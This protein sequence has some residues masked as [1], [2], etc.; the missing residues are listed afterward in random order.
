LAET[1]LRDGRHVIVFVNDMATLI[2]PGQGS[3]V[4]PD[5]TD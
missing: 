1:N 3:A 5:E 2:M 4:R